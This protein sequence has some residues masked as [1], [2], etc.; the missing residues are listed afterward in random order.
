MS[1]VAQPPQ[2]RS[3][4]VLDNDA[5][6]FPFAKQRPPSFA[7]SPL[8]SSL[9][10]LPFDQARF[11]DPLDCVSGA[12]ERHQDRLLKQRTLALITKRDALQLHH[13]R[14][15]LPCC[16]GM[17]RV[18]RRLVDQAGIHQDGKVRCTSVAG[19]DGSPQVGS[20]DRTATSSH[21]GASERHGIRPTAAPG[22]PSALSAPIACCAVHR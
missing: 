6:I 20:P 2:P 22:A 16:R 11:L 5:K 18:A 10:H 4:R 7:L 12:V 8:L 15:D 14:D 21:P 1:P 3:S 9:T 17:R 19:T 13:A